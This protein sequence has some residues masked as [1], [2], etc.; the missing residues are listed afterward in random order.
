MDGRGEEWGEGGGRDGRR[1]D[2]MYVG[3]KGRSEV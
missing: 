2:R 1:D 3:I